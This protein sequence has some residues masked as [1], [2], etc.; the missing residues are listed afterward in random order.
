MGILVAIVTT[1][2]TAI[3]TCFLTQRSVADSRLLE[4]TNFTPPA[5][6][7]LHVTLAR[8]HKDYLISA[9]IFNTTK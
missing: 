5:D 4:H 1:I 3:F 7:A 6:T 8:S 9:I 2:Q